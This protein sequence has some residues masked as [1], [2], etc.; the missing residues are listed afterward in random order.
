MVVSAGGPGSDG[1]SPLEGCERRLT[2]QRLLLD[3]AV[4]QD[5]I[6]MFPGNREGT[7]MAG[8]ASRGRP[9]V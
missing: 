3:A 6:H 4:R 2:A 5:V 7:K 1:P 9:G 8:R